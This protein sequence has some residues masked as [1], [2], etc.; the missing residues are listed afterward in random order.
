MEITFKVRAELPVK[1]DSHV[2]IMSMSPLGDNHVEILPGTSQG[3]FAPDGSLLPSE[4][5]VDFNALTAQFNDL[6][7]HAPQLIVAF[8]DPAAD[9][10]ATL[11]PVNDFLN[12]HNR[13]NL[14]A[15]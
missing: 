6:T 11:A 5:Y 2:K 13:A 14:S 7:P 15:T 9:L 12:A 3:A 1:T 10:K 8:N 4:N